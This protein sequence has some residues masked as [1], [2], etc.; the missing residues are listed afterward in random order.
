MLLE[1]IGPTITRHL[2]LALQG[3]PAAGSLRAIHV[4]KQTKLTS[5]S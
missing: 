5:I 4:A 2:I 1:S 3:R